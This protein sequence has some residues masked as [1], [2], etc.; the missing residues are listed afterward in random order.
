MKSST[1]TTANNRSRRKVSNSGKSWFG[2]CKAWSSRHPVLLTLIVLAIA[3]FVWFGARPFVSYH[4]AQHK[5]GQLLAAIPLAGDRQV[6]ASAR[7][8]ECSSH[9][10]GWFGSATTCAFGVTKIIAIKGDKK[11]LSTILHTLNTKLYDM[12]Y[13]GDLGSGSIEAHRDFING[14]GS[15]ATFLAQ[16][17]GTKSSLNAIRVELP[18]KPYDYRRLTGIY[19][20]PMPDLDGYNYLVV[21]QGIVSY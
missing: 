11:K 8:L 4:L 1:T 2:A 12:G 19:D 10:T 3:A 20:T 6:H 14:E 16:D 7:D 9:D 18:T 21:V 15:S 17:L 13:E 5:A